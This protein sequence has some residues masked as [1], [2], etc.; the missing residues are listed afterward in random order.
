MPAIRV[1]GFSNIY[2]CISKICLIFK[3]IFILQSQNNKDSTR[4]KEYGL[5]SVIEEPH[6]TDGTIVN[7]YEHG[8]QILLSKQMSKVQCLKMKTHVLA[9][10]AS[11]GEVK[12][13]FGL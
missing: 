3:Y 8:N 7:E 6:G 11:N 10:P 5:M 1:I 2:F 13:G 12:L 4:Q 9:L